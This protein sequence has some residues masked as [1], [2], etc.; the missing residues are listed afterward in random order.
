MDKYKV[1]IEKFEGPLDLLLQLIEKEKLN[2]TEI[3][4][5]KVTNQFLEYINKLEQIEAENLADFLIIAS[6]LILIKSRALLPELDLPG[7]DEISAEELALRL[8]EYKKFKDQA[9]KINEIYE[10]NK[11]SFEQEFYL[12]KGNIFAPGKNLTDESLLGAMRS[13]FFSFSKFKELARKTVRQTVSIKEKIIYLQKLISK[14]AKI[15]FK[16]IVNKTKNKLDAV[17]SFLALLELVK[18][19]V[20]EV[21]QKKIFSDIIFKRKNK[22]QNNG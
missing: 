13:I 11:V 22:I 14:E 5:E 9:Q 15:K 10:N 7:E 6:Q 17:V 12:Q 2:I 20:I 8:K 3:S 1:N 16:N 21:D 18:Q 4:L 19:Q